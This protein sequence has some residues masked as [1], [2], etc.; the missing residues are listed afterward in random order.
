IN[1]ADRMSRKGIELDIPFLEE[2]LNTK[3][4]LISAREG[5]G[6][7]A[8]KELIVNYK[9]L[10]KEPCLDTAAIEPAYFEELKAAFPKENLYKLWVAITEQL[11][12][13]GVPKDLNKV[14]T[15]FNTKS[16]EAVKRMQHRETVLRYKFINESLKKGLHIRPENAKGF[17]AKLDRIL[18]HRVW[19]YLIFAAILLVIFQVIYDWSGIPMDFIDAQ[20]ANLS[21]WCKSILPEGILAD[22]LTDGVIPGIG[23]VVIF[24]PQIAFLFLFIAIL[25]ESGYMSRVV[26]LM[27]RV[28]RPFGLSGKSV[29]PLMS[30]TACAIPAV[31]A[32]RNI[33]S[34]KER[35]I[36]ILVVPFTTCSARLPVYLIIIALII[37]EGNVIGFSYKALSL[38]GLYLIGFVA[39]LLSAYI[40]KQFWKLP[41]KSFFIIELPTYRPPLVKNVLYTVLEK[42]KSFV[43]GAGKIILS[44]SIIIWF[45]ASNGPGEEFANAEELVA[46]AQ[47]ETLSEAALDQKIAS[48]RLRHSYIGIMG[49]AIEPTIRPLGYDWK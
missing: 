31:M 11:Q 49:N 14:T 3:I 20:F 39:A 5:T 18:I 24:I 21:E 17:T 38:M 26:F 33:D 6:I 40:L 16:K 15:T 45:L 1:M 35:L 7:D 46:A 9:Q 48:H 42:T 23:G 12:G 34:W 36:T 27:D 43:F 44:I 47:T 32:A 4:A 37:P 10:S 28:M 13:P 2:N 22:L 41:S 29:V 30:G 25:E 8:L 19:G